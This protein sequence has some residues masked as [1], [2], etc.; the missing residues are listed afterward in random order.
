MAAEI[1]KLEGAMWTFV[2]IEGLEPTNNYGERI[3]RHAV[4]YRKTSFGT[5]S[6]DGSRFVE[7]IMTTVMTLKQQKRNVLEFLT[8]AIYAHRRGLPAPSLLPNMPAQL[9]IAA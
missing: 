4:M 2:Q 6:P 5:Q 1:L 3:I 7:R 9:A 8:T